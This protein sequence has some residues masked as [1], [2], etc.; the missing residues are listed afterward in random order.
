MRA[1]ALPVWLSLLLPLR[2]P[3]PGASGGRHSACQVCHSAKTSCNGQRPCDRCVR[4]DRQS[5]CVDRPRKQ[6]IRS[7]EEEGRGRRSRRPRTARKSDAP[8]LGKEGGPMAVARLKRVAVKR[9]GRRARRG[10]T[11]SATA[12]QGGRVA[13]LRPPFPSDDPQMSSSHRLRA[14][15]TALLVLLHAPALYRGQL[16]LPVVAR[17]HSSSASGESSTAFLCLLRVRDRLSVRRR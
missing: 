9:G 17:T 14:H 12:D 10:G 4:L 13:V 11:R 2:Q 15:L 1:A 16:L 8:T 3:P 7:G 5:L 6:P